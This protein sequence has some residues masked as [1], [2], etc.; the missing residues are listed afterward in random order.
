[1]NLLNFK[2]TFFFMQKVLFC[3][4]VGILIFGS[5]T[6]EPDI[7]D[8]PDLIQ[9]GNDFLAYRIIHDIIRDEVSGDVFIMGESGSGISKLTISRLDKNF[10][11]I[12]T[13]QYFPES[14]YYGEQMILTKA[15]HLAIISSRLSSYLLVIDLDGEKIT[16]R[17]LEGK[18]SSIAEHG[19][20][21][22]IIA[23]ALKGELY[24]D[25]SIITLDSNG[26]ILKSEILVEGFGVDVLD[27]TNGLNNEVIVLYKFLS[28][29]RPFSV[30]KIDSN[31]SVWN[32]EYF[33]Y[34]L[35]N[36]TLW[37][38]IEITGN[39]N[40]VIA[41]GDMEDSRSG[42]LTQLGEDGQVIW[43]Q[44]IGFDM[45]DVLQN[46]ILTKDGHFVVSGSTECCNNSQNIFAAKIDINGKVIWKKRYGNID[47]NNSTCL[48]YMGNGSILIGGYRNPKDANSFFA[49]LFEIDENGIVK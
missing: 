7:I 26:G 3:F 20:N 4:L 42:L 11:E 45:G 34:N 49:T 25:L 6:K 35:S 28:G 30:I 15:K 36:L 1:M 21:G 22:F 13:K 41:T 37:S 23:G 48:E 31:G 19:N 43:T 44:V 18:Y 16:E 24:E 12:W 8:D 2:H 27:M 46:V 40:I 38:D 29:N 14:S 47:T 5:C 32:K 17:F 10:N 33:N 9:I 39:G